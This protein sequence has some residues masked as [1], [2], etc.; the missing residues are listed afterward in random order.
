[1]KFMQQFPKRRKRMWKYVSPKRQRFGLVV[2]AILI[3]LVYAEWYFTNDIRIRREAEKALEKLIAADVEIEHASF[4]FF[5]GVRLRGVKVRI[6][7]DDSPYNFLTARRVVLKHNP[8]GLLLRGR[9][10]PTDIVCI[11]PV[12]T[13]EYDKDHGQ[14]NAAALF[15]KAAAQSRGK[16]NSSPMPLPQIHLAGGMLRTVVKQG[17]VRNPPDEESI[18]CSLIPISEST[19]EVRVEESHRNQE[20]IEWVRFVLNVS[21]GQVEEIAGSASARFF[22]LLPPDYRKWIDRYQL[23]GD[24]SA[25]ESTEVNGDKQ[26]RIKLE[27]FS[28]TLPPEQGDFAIKDV[29]GEIVFSSKGV[30]LQGITGH[31]PDIGQAEL[32]LSGQYDG[33]SK[34]SP[35]EIT[36]VLAGASLPDKLTG[37]L[38]ST[39]DFINSQFKP[40]GK[41][42]IEVTYSR[43]PSGKF[44]CRGEIRPNAM[45]MEC[46]YFPLPVENVKGVLNF[47]VS[48]DKKDA[49][50]TDTGLHKDI[51]MVLT[52]RQKNGGGKS[53]GLE[54]SGSVKDTPK[55]QS[56]DITVKANGAALNDDLRDALPPLFRDAWDEI[57]PS[58]RSSANV[59]VVKLVGEE[60]PKVDVE[61]IMEGSAGIQYKHF[62]YPLRNISGK[63]YIRNDEVDIEWAHSKMGDMTCDIKGQI[64]GLSGKHPTVDLS[65]HAMRVPLD[66]NVVN[67]FDGETKKIIASLGLSG[68]AGKIV[69][70]VTRKP[71]KDTEFDFT[72]SLKNAGFKYDKFPYPVTNAAGEILV[73]RDKIEIKKVQGTHGKTTVS[74]GGTVVRAKLGTGLNLEISADGVELDDE[75]NKAMAKLPKAYKVY[76]T[77]DPK[78]TTD[79]TLV[80]KKLPAA[81]DKDDLDYTLTLT[82]RGMSICP[83]AFPYRFR[84]IT[85]GAVITPGK[86]VL[87]KAK[88]KHGTMTAV[89]SGDVLQDGKGEK[90]NL[91]VSA[92]N[93]PVDRELIAAF[94]KMGL[95]TNTKPGGRCNLDIQKLQFE[96][97][98]DENAKTDAAKNAKVKWSMLGSIAF[99]DMQFDFG[100]GYKKITGWVAGVASRN[101]KGQLG[102]HADAELMSLT[103]KNHLVTS[104]K[105]KL[106][107]KP[108]SQVLR[109]DDIEGRAHDGKISGT[110]D[111][112]FSDPIRFELSIEMQNVDMAKLFNAGVED[113]TKW[114]DVNGKLGGTLALIMTGGKKP[115]REAEGDL[116]ISKAEMFEVPVV[117]GL[118]NVIYLSVPGDSAFNSGLVNYHLKNDKLQFNE[119][120]L[121]G[122]TLSILGAGSLNLKT[123]ELAL[124]FLT[125]PPGKMPRLSELAEDILRALSKELVEIR[126]TGTTKNPKMETV[127]LRSLRK[128]IERMMPKVEE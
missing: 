65:I 100:F 22:R 19:Y 28:L 46:G 55:E 74:I 86:V 80:L 97:I 94:E 82:P 18:N 2:L 35:F 128:I 31:V 68:T 24:F 51:T 95:R 103:H 124:R 106:D 108:S 20:K 30:R 89:I 76:K 114:R 25:L 101:E 84:G 117:L 34:D 90:A 41:A 93:V 77:F 78:G 21:N 38:G 7:G 44:L 14:N 96:R 105:G 1:Q 52:A 122:K 125:G 104:I 109:I 32:K 88:V 62:A 113:K 27:D 67:A 56:Y 8:W 102:V 99:R 92:R 70:T 59:H 6:I 10:E 107:K 119:I 3:S 63:V 16:S 45:S 79:L 126:V 61:I 36:V 5:E 9:L 111:V 121:T 81:S 83:E 12:V 26:F 69:G 48:S 29:S 47:V 64:K 50:Q 17:G 85:G 13:I 49:Q 118:L 112:R 40:D 33:Y 115:T 4:S 58:G 98:Y 54:I 110:A 15:K 120:F 127:A 60:N 57:S 42:D 75:F 87:Q 123:D 37:T 71:E 72:V 91:S 53:G 73:K 116:I 66:K 39:V 43:D 11:D 23:Q